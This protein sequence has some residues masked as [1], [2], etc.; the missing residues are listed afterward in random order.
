MA[1]KESSFLGANQTM[2]FA[3]MAYEKEA[4]LENQQE[5]QN[6]LYELLYHSA[7]VYLS[8]GTELSQFESRDKMMEMIRSEAAAGETHLLV[9]GAKNSDPHIVRFNKNGEI[10]GYTITSVHPDVYLSDYGPEDL[11]PEN[12]PPAP[13]G[14]DKFVNGFKS[15]FGGK[16]KVVKDYE[17]YQAKRN[18]YLSK[19]GFHHN[20]GTVKTEEKVE[21]V[22]LDTE[23]KYAVDENNEELDAADMEL[24]TLANLVRPES[25]GYKINKEAG[26]WLAK[27]MFIVEAIDPRDERL[28]GALNDSRLEREWEPYRKFAQKIYDLGKEDKTLRDALVVMGQN[29]SLEKLYGAYKKQFNDGKELNL[30]GLMNEVVRGKNKENLVKLLNNENINKHV[31]TRIVTTSPDEGVFKKVDGKQGPGFG[32]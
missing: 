22:T 24:K 30:E 11:K 21:D 19:M 15:I 13:N 9:C 5:L 31:S 20:T 10:T 3:A 16:G 17:E 26:D 28:K 23:P 14:W 1:K 32:K 8:D 12:A 7:E 6:A 18:E 27:G 4:N 25:L 29:G 2:A